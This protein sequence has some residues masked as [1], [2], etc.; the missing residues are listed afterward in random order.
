[1]VRVEGSPPLRKTPKAVIE[2]SRLRMKLEKAEARLHEV[3]AGLAETVRPRLDRAHQ[4]LD[5]AVD[6][7][8]EVDAKRRDLLVR[9]RTA[10]TDIARSWKVTLRDSRDSLSAARQEWREAARLLSRIPEEI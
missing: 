10:S 4:A 7:W 2:K 3:P 8:H 9:G 5:R 1:M 6:L